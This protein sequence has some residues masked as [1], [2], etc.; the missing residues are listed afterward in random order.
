MGIEP[1]TLLQHMESPGLELSPTCR[2]VP[3]PDFLNIYYILYPIILATFIIIYT[4]YI[5]E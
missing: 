4:I 3:P 1:A 5:A 2:V